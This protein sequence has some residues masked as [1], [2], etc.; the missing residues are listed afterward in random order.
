MS[1]LT[2][3]K[4]DEMCLP[5]RESFY[6]SLTGDTVFESDYAHAANVWQRF[7]IRMLG[8]AIYISKPTSCC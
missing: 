3:E 4:L 6:S 8:I 1:T 7:S 2:A 5:S